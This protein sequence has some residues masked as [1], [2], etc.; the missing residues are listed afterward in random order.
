MTDF[1]KFKS[2]LKAI[3]D[4]LSKEYSS[5]RT[6]KATP[7]ILD[8][9]IVDSYGSKMKVN[10]VAGVSIEDPK[11][12]RVAPWDKTQIK[13]IEKAILDA[14]LG[15]SVNTDEAGLRVIFPDLTS[16]R[17]DALIKVSKTKLE[18][19]RV[20]LRKE[21]DDTKH[22]IDE[23]SSNEDEAFRMKEEMQKIVDEENKKLEEM[24]EAKEKEIQG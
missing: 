19:A 23:E 12:L 11:T 15:L 21:R 14:D 17:R 6:G 20:S 24:A 4:W 16:E 1:S 22:S 9:V 8:G 7:S 18:E 13:D 3:E 5:L 2:D 10:Q